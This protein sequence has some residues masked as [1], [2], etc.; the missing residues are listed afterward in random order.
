MDFRFGDII[1]NEWASETNPIRRGVFVRYTQRR[2]CIELTD[3]DGKF[4]EIGIDGDLAPAKIKRV[5]TIWT[6]EN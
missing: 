1:E 4:W 6:K 5:S 3:M 2:R